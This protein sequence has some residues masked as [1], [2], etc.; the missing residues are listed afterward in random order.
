MRGAVFFSGM[1]RIR[2]SWP[3][4]FVLACAIIAILVFMVFQQV[5][6]WPSRFFDAFSHE[7]AGQ[8][9][10]VRDILADSFQLR[11][12]ISVKDR[13]VYEQSQNVLELVDRPD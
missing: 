5:E 11:P 1:S 12:R 9:E 2:I 6:N 3:L 10:K 7:S 8:L 4:A 13:V